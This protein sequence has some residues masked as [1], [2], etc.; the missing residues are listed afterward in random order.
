MCVC[1]HKQLAYA[2]HTAHMHT[3]THT[4]THTP[5]T[6]THTQ[7]LP[8]ASHIPTSHPAP[9][10]AQSVTTEVVGGRERVPCADGLPSVVSMCVHTP[11][12]YTVGCAVLF[13]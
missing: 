2:I 1:V 10:G 5:H 3:H 6:H 7:D 9:P 11:P 8:P 12:P 4:H 13:V